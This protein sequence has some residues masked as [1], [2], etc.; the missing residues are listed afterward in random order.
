MVRSPDL[1]PTRARVLVLATLLARMAG[2][3]SSLYPSTLA[4]EW[5]SDC[6]PTRAT[7][8]PPS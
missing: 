7:R 1:S 8:Q 6:A 2:L 3:I 5:T 4:I